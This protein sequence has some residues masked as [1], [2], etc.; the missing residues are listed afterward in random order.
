MLLYGINSIV[1]C[2]IKGHL[3]IE[4]RT[5]FYAMKLACACIVIIILLMLVSMWLHRLV[6]LPILMLY[7]VCYP[8]GDG[9]LHMDCV[10]WGCPVFRCWYDLITAALSCLSFFQ[11]L[12]LLEGH[13]LYIHDSFQE[14]LFDQNGWDHNNKYV[15]VLPHFCYIPDSAGPEIHVRCP[16]VSITSKSFWN[17][18]IPSNSVKWSKILVTSFLVCSSKRNIS[19]RLQFR[20]NI[21]RK[22]GLVPFAPSTVSIST[23]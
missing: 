22:Q 6:S 9:I 12:F 2:M 15:C 21:V 8:A 17:S 7:E 10:H 23:I 18:S 14:H 13:T 11:S 20:K 4:C 16:S 5:K 3:E 1:F 19:I